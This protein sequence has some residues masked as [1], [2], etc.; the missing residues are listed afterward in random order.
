[1]AGTIL[2]DFP[3]VPGQNIRNFPES[4]EF[5]EISVSLLINSNIYAFLLIILVGTTIKSHPNCD[6]DL[7]S[8]FGST[9]DTYVAYDLDHN[10]A[11]IKFFIS[12]E[13]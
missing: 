3:L 4:P 10:S 7:F 8:I 13:S 2:M 11:T 6:F 5:F 1:M 9:Q 12:A